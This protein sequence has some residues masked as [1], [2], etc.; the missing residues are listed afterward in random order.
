[1][2]ACSGMTPHSFKQPRRTV[3]VQVNHQWTRSKGG[4][5]GACRSRGRS[6]VARCALIDGGHLRHRR[7]HCCAGL[8]ADG[9]GLRKCSCATKLRSQKRRCRGCFTLQEMV[10]STVV[11]GMSSQPSRDTYAD[12]MY[13]RA[14][15]ASEFLSYSKRQCI[16]SGRDASHVCWTDIVP[17]ELLQVA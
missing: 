13:M 14:L 16:F 5:L 15:S 1:M 6:R 17:Q 10:S 9:L 3:W 7:G 12:Q 11:P 4:S 2:T 8:R